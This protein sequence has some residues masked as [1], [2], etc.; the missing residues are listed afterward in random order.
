MNIAPGTFVRSGTTST[1]PDV[2]VEKIQVLPTNFETG[3]Q[4]IDVTLSL[5]TV[6]DPSTLWKV[7]YM[8]FVGFSPDRKTIKKMVKN[9]NLVKGLIRTPTRTIGHLVKRYV[10]PPKRGSKAARRDF[11][12]KVIDKKLGTRLAKV[13]VTIQQEFDIES[14]ENLYIYATAYARDPQSVSQSGVDRKIAAMKMSA[15]AI[16]VIMQEGHTPLTATAFMLEKDMEGYGKRGD[17]WGGPMHVSQTAADSRPTLMAGAEHKEEAHPTLKPERVSNQKIQDLR[18]LNDI[19]RL[20]FTA[21]NNKSQVLS[22]RERKNLETA[23]KVVKVPSKVSDCSYSRTKDNKLKIAFAVD[24]DRLSKDNTRLG[25]FIRNPTTLA[26]CFQIENIRLYRTRV[27]PNIQPNELTP[28]K[29]NICGSSAATSSEKLVGSL[30][31][32]TIQQVSF[33]G[34]TGAVRNFISTD[35]EMAHEHHG[36][37]QYRVAIDM[38][39]SSTTAATAISAKLSKELAEYNKFLAAADSMG[40]KGF[41]IKERLKRDKKF[42]KGLNKE[43]ESLINCYMASIK[44]FFGASAFGHQSSVAWRKNLIAMVNPSNGDILSMKRVSEI[45]SQFNTNLRMMFAPPSTPT[46]A[47]AFSVRSRMGSQSTAQRKVQLEHVF[48]STYSRT[49][50]ASTGTD[51]L[52]NTL[53]THNASGYTSMAY[54]SYFERINNELKKYNVPRP[55]DPGINKFGFLSPARLFSGG[56]VVETSTAQL[57]QDVANGILNASLAPDPNSDAFV[58]DNSSDKVYKEEINSIL[59]FSDIAMVPNTMPLAD[60]VSDPEPVS[61]VTI[62]SSFFLPAGPIGTSFNKDSLAA[63]T[64]AS[65]SNLNTMKIRRPRTMQIGRSS[66][67]SFFV[68]RKASGFKPLPPF[69][70]APNIRGS[71]AAEAAIQAPNNTELN[72]SFGN[73]VNFNSIVEVQYF[74]GY[75]VSNGIINLNAPIWRTM[76]KTVF[77]DSRIKYKRQE[78]HG[79]AAVPPLLCRILLTTKSMQMK[80]L[81]ALPEYDNLFILGSAAPTPSP[82]P[83]WEKVYEAIL[84][85]TKVETKNVAFNIGGPLSNID[86]AYLKSP[87]MI[88]HSHGRKHTNQQNQVGGV[89]NRGA[90]DSGIRGNGKY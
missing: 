59:G 41:N 45:V 88:K 46:S 20:Q 7:P 34:N 61:Q 35:E 5:Q 28:G 33:A 44:F 4:R 69:R 32:G 54:D 53:V 31:D 89:V 30:K 76:T 18:F 60:I 87:V 84:K 23:A 74:D 50:S 40:E 85:Q 79:G 42:L 66:A 36:D 64:A 26:G 24:Y 19:A 58:P 90:A 70:A 52:D 29:I 16:E 47:T 22:P 3:K 71:I 75:T 86:S 14:L 37:F 11:S 57:V 77:D 67:A 10:E 80:N 78:L 39:D 12:M 65:G 81:Y 15:P 68:N 56:S 27:L 38:V 48:R 43:W 25:R 8:I 13:A 49:T 2:F 6:L 62:M 9:E 83:R 73:S 63:S 17:V 1:L 55:N 51:Y 21:S 72:S 82:S